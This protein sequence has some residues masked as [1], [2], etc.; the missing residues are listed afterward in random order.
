MIDYIA[1]QRAARYFVRCVP[2][3]ALL[4]V[5]DYAQEAALLALL[6]RKSR[7]G[8][9]YDLLRRHGWITNHRAT[10]RYRRVELTEWRQTSAPEPIWS[11]AID[12]RRMLAKLTYRQRQAVEMH[13]LYGMRESEIVNKLRI[14][15]SAVRNRIHEGL[16][17]MRRM[18]Q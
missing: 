10:S 3:A 13:Y 6:G 4:D 17:N 18:I 12:V 1:I 7:D 14:S 2:D 16:R 5:N 8:P 15:T 11:A 9:M